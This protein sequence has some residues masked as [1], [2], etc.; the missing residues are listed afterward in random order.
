MYN[1]LFEQIL[2]EDKTRF[3]KKAFSAVFGPDFLEEYGSDINGYDYNDIIKFVNSSAVDKYK[4]DWQE[5]PDTLYNDILDAYEQYE[6]AGGSRTQQAISLKGDP[7]QFFTKNKGLIEEKD[8][9]FLSSLEN[10]TYYFVQPLSY[11]CCVFMDSFECGGQGAKWCLGYKENDSYWNNYCND[12]DLFVFVFNKKEFANKTNKEDKLKF[13]IEL[14]LDRKKTQVWKQSDHSNETTKLDNIKAEFGYDANE[15]L[16]VVLNEGRIDP[17]RN[18]N[19]WRAAKKA[20]DNGKAYYQKRYNPEYSYTI[21]M[22]EFYKEIFNSGQPDW[23]FNYIAKQQSNNNKKRIV[24][25][26]YDMKDINSIDFPMNLVNLG[27]YQ[28]DEI[29][30]INLNI[31]SLKFKVKADIYDGA[32]SEMPEFT[33]KLTFEGC[34]IGKVEANHWFMKV[35]SPYMKVLFDES[36]VVGDVTLIVDS[37]FVSKDDVKHTYNM[38]NTY[39]GIPLHLMIYDSVASINEGKDVYKSYEEYMEN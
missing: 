22:A 14:S 29:I 27:I 17:I 11:K 35:N 6:A 28:F 34:N 26:Y 2:R 21:N 25:D 36:C 15:I 31:D 38:F 10:D 3:V 4:I 16:K 33:G 23:Y 30:I 20:L 1:R 37:D 7:K 19:A 18:H 9:V 32:I 39:G 13:M 24:L 8:Y 12:N 5:A